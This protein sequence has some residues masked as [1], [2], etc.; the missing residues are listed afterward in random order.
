MKSEML[1]ILLTSV[2][3]RSYLVEYFI[4]ALNGRGEVH[5]ANST[6]I[7]PAFIVADKSVVTPLIYDDNYVDFLIEYSKKNNIKAIISLFDIDLM[8]LAQNKEKFLENGIEVI[9]SDERVISICN[10]K[11]NTYRFLKDNGF[12]VPKT[13]LSIQKVKQEICDKLLTFPLILKPRWGMGSIGVYQADNEEELDCLY[14]KILRDIQNSYLKYESRK[15]PE[16][17]VLIQEKLEGQEYGLDVINDLHG[18]YISTSVKKKYAMRSG[19][20]DCAITV[21]NPQLR[22]VGKKL[23]ENLKHVANLDTDVFISNEKIYILELNARFGGGYPFSHCA[24]VNLPQAIINWL[25]NDK[26]DNAN[27]I[28]TYNVLSHKDIKIVQLPLNKNREI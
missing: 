17:C 18:N 9:V 19:E 4:H 26:N 27:L 13:Y 25:L 21:D 8:V 22:N 6:E 10:D 20:T 5:V 23:S 3:R 1:N 15:T 2:G 24:G 12:N 28:P 7:S 11:W 16:Q 14:K